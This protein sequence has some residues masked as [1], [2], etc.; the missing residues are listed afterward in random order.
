VVLAAALLTAGVVAGVAQAAPSA[1][2]PAARPAPAPQWVGSWATVPTTVPPSSTTA[3]AD[4]TLRQTVHLSV[5]GSAVRVRF[6]NEFGT[7]PLRIGEARV[8]R[9]D[10]SPSTVDV[11]SDRRLTF[12]GRTSVVVPAGAPMVSDPV[13]LAVPAG[14]DLVVSLWLPERTAATTT[15]GF[16]FQDNVV[17]AGNVTGR[18][19]VTPTATFQ[20]WEFLS[21]VAVSGP[22]RGTVVTLGDSITDG[23]TT[24][25]NAN[26]RWPD[27][28]AARF[29]ATPGLRDLGV[30]NAGIT[31]NRLLHDPNPLAGSGAEAYAAQFGESALR[32]FDRDVGAQP[33]A[34]YLVVLLGVNDLGHPGNIAP[35]SE[36]V[37]AADLIGGYRQLIAR[38]H[39]RGLRVY[40]A[41]ILPHG[42]DTY[43]YDT[44]ANEAARQAVNRWI[45]TSGEYDGVIDLDAAV[46]D[47]AVPSRLRPSFD[48]GDGLHPNDAGAAAMARAVPLGL[49]R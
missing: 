46:R 44:P 22:A 30:V 29:R 9:S 14:S 36:T 48:S 2:A 42:G 25:A 7:V 28:L 4:Q 12:G 24:T 26:R 49:F 37:T 40:G 15:H 1:P 41:T 32:R 3:F 10:G 34:R 8:A 35:L 16:S 43:G 27:V 33:G 13:R 5:G 17:A 6:T 18:R 23:S 19:A 39:E 45:R 20:R 47:P 31:G 11:R 38:G 21:G